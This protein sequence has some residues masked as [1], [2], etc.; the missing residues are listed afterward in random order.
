[1]ANKADKAEYLPRRAEPGERFTFTGAD[2]V[3]HDVQ[4]DDDGVIRPESAEQD[5]WLTQWGLPVAR[6]VV[7]DEKAASAVEPDA[8]AEIVVAG[9]QEVKT[10]G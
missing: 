1:M 4:A 9:K 3:P 10:D 2:G 6:K 8:T 7:N 5:G